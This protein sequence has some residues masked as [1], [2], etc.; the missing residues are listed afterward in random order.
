VAEHEGIEVDTAETPEIPERETAEQGKGSAQE[1]TQVSEPEI[2]R[3]RVQ[4]LESVETF[5]GFDERDYD[6]EANDVVSLPATN[7]EILL[8]RGVAREL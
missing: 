3:R 6:L 8:E 1:D 4:I 7:A 2:E 5:M